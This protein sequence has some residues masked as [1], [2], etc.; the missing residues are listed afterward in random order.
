MWDVVD[1]PRCQT[2][3]ADC[4]G[5][6]H[7]PAPSA[8]SSHCWSVWRICVAVLLLFTVCSP[9]AAQAAALSLE[10]EATTTTALNLR[11]GPGTE[12]TVHRVI[13][14]GASVYINAGPVKTEW[15]RVRYRGQRGYVH[16]AY[17]TQSAPHGGGS[18]P[19]A[20]T[21]STIDLSEYPKRYEA[22]AGYVYTGRRAQALHHLTERYAT[23]VTTYAGH[24]ACATCSADLWTPGAVGG[25]DNT[26]MES[27]ND[28]AN[29]IRAHVSELRI[30]YV[31]WNN[32][33]S[34]GGAW[35]KLKTQGSI[36][37]KH[38]DHVH[39]TFRDSSK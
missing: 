4:V 5:R 34:S 6:V 10:A 17:L 2:T 21:T 15:Y 12:Y 35:R 23:R 8:A 36:T 14:A 19:E 7:H 39:I 37:A 24:A 25:K 1:S 33:Y 32:R 9:A 31:I 20:A 18:T 29:Y 16:G 30:K 27:M 22:N 28:L 26:D 13:P 3:P 38:K 11:A